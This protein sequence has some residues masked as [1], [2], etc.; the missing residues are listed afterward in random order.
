M[1]T[2]DVYDLMAR[3]GDLPYGEA[4]TV[5]VEDAL[6]RAEAAGDEVLAF[7][8]RMELTGAYQYGGEPAK[9]FTTFSR[10]LSQH[11]RDPGRFDQAERLLWHFKWVVGSL[12]L[13]PE[14]PLDRT[15]A[16]LDDMERRYRLGGHSLHAVYSYRHAVARHV[17]D[18]DAAEEWYAKW[19]A[20][21]RDQLSDCEGCDP[22]S[23]ARYQAEQ[24]RH[25]EALAVAVPVLSAE[26]NCTEQPQSIL[27]NV[28]M[29]FV[30][31]GRLEEAG[32][33]HRRAYRLLRANIRDLID[34][35]EHVRF[36]ALTGNE[37]RG[38][39]IL[40]RHLGWLDRAP[41]PAAAMDFAAAGALLL[42]R[43][44]ETGA[45]D[46]LTL[47]RGSAEVPAGALREELAGRAR[48]LAA[49]FD[50]R[51]G[52]SRQGDLVEAT[53]TAEPLVEHLPLTPYARRP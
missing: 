8:V 30:H 51:N 40:E 12:K 48:E 45:D 37:A 29:S 52:T 49:R 36:C 35:A 20:A 39:E 31:T 18:A 46:G 53:L 17:G 11:D 5:L 25:D 28:L 44:A 43:I 24:G 27:T 41:S 21:P 1:S 42:R 16:V 22:S 9:A 34:I 4:R 10:C 50:A 15:Y 32:Q 3:A 14:I 47:R 13:F 19:Q 23:K 7:R 26:I 2:D 33:A 38:L 6:R